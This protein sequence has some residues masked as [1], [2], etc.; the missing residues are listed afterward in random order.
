MQHTLS[1]KKINPVAMADNK[2]VAAIVRKT[3]ES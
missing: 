2:K 3:N 1:N